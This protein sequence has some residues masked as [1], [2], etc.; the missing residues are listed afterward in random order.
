MNGTCA[1]H[2]VMEVKMHQHAND[3]D[4]FLHWLNNASTNNITAT[5]S[6]PHVL[7]G[8]LFGL[9]VLKYLEQCTV[10]LVVVAT[11]IPLE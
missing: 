10:V 8:H 7:I 2:G 9:I 3:E 5:A 4:T 1:G 11:K 6:L